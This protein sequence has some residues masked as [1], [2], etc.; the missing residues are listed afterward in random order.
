VNPTITDNKVAVGSGIGSFT[1][2]ISILTPNTTYYARAYATNSVGTSY[3]E[4]QSLTSLNAY[5]EGF[6]NGYPSSWSGNGWGVTNAVTP[7]EGYGCLQAN[8]VN[9]YVQLTRTV[10]TSPNG[11]ISFYYKGNCWISCVST[12]FYID[13]VLQAT[14]SEG[15]WTLHSY[16]VTTGTHTFKWKVINNNNSM[17]AFIDYI[18]VSP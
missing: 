9:D 3:G 2:S 1:T 16:S 10:T 8:Q 7:Y 17:G 15:S 13:N 6:E 11:N 5:Y 4:N 14:F 18:L 12:E